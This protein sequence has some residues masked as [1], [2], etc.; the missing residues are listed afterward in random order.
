[1]KQIRIFVFDT[2]LL[3]THELDTTLIETIHFGIVLL[4]TIV[5]N[6]EFNLVSIYTV[7]FDLIHILEQLWNIFGTIMIKQIKF[8]AV[9]LFTVEF[10]IVSSIATTELDLYLHTLCVTY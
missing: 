2:V 6:T 10:E 8:D 5:I 7:I 9:L 4:Y 1:M 3:N